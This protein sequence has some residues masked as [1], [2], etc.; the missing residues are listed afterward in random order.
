MFRS[1]FGKQKRRPDAPPEEEGLKDARVGDVITVSGLSPDYDDAYLIVEKINRYE[2]AT[3]NWYE[4]IC[5]DGDRRVTIEWS[6]GDD[7]FVTASEAGRPL[8]LSSI[9]VTAD[10][11]IR[12]DETQS[13]DNQVAYEGRKFYYRNSSE[14]SFYPDDSS[15]GEGFYLWDFTS[16]DMSGVISVVKWE[17]APFEVYVSEVVPPE[18]INVYR[19]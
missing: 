6:P 15:E 17:G 10:D 3:G 14:V 1:L 5:A 18:S 8:S 16:E 11:L 4:L 2:G 9:G 12:M 19:R 7:Q 13:V